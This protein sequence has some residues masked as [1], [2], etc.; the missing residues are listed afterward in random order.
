MKDPNLNPP[1]AYLYCAP[2]RVENRSSRL[3]DRA[4][5]RRRGV[6]CDAATPRRRGPTPPRHD[7]SRHLLFRTDGQ[8]KNAYGTCV[9]FEP[10]NETSAGG[11]VIFTALAGSGRDKVFPGG[12]NQCRNQTF[13]GIG[14]EFVGREAASPP[15]G[16]SANAAGPTRRRRG[17]FQCLFR[18]R[19]N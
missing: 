2:A 1:S 9:D 8:G 13:Q 19:I 5:R 14:A 15:R 16:D 4:T 11:R 12:I 3:G 6:G 17:M 10:D 18:P 7:G